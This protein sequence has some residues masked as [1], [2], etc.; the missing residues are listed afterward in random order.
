M[1]RSLVLG[2]ALICGNPCE[3]LAQ[4]GNTFFGHSYAVV[5]GIDNYTDA[6][7]PKLTHAVKDARAFAAFLSNQGFTVIERY[8]QYATRASIISILEES[9]VSIPTKDDRVLLFFAGHGETRPGAR[10]DRGFLVPVDASDDYSSLIPVTTLQVLSSDSAAR[11]HLFVL[12]ACFG[13]LAA[14]RSG[15]KSIDRTVP[16]Y[17]FRISQ[18]PARQLLT[19]GGPNERVLDGGPDGHS[20]FMGYLLRALQEGVGDGD[21]DGYVTTTE[22]FNYVRVA[23]STYGQTPIA[24]YFE[25]HEGGISGSSTRHKRGWPAKPV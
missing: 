13:G 6:R 25:G 15:A 5:I 19:A 16:N 9:F 1:L 17:L 20:Y 22:L 12:D 4:E 10:G 7:R 21:N 11:H 2:L 24:D 23:A 14:R 8:D 18:R 3:L